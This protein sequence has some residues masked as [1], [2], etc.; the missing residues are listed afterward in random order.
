MRIYELA[1]EL[2]MNSKDLCVLV[3]KELGIPVKNHMS[4]LTD[5]EVLRFKKALSLMNSTKKTKVVKG[6]KNVVIDDEPLV[7]EKIDLNQAKLKKV[8]KKLIS[9]VKKPA[10]TKS[11]TGKPSQETEKKEFKKDPGKEK[12]NQ[13]RAA[14]KADKRKNRKEKQKQLSL[15][16]WRKHNGLY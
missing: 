12:Q 7:D 14:G 13:K 6:G 3:E 4:S 16:I 8:D 2:E 1:K 5:L 10:S 11:K 15:Y 9:P